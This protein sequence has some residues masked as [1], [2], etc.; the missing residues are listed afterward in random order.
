MAI[1]F[2]N[3]RRIQYTA[4]VGTTIF[5]YPFLIFEDSDLDV[6][7][8]PLGSTPDPSTDLLTLNVDYTVTGILDQGGGNV[9]LI[10]PTTGG[11]TIT[12]DSDV[13][14][15]QQ[16][17][18]AVGGLF[19]PTTVTFVV[20]K[21]TVLI[22]EIESLI[23]DQGLLYDV[24]APLDT[25][26]DK[27][28]NRLPVLGLPSTGKI[29]VWTKNATGAIIA[30]ELDENI[31][32]SALRGELA[33]P[34]LASPGADL[35]GYFDPIVG[36]TTV[37]TTLT[38]LRNAVLT[39]LFTT[40]DVKITLKV[41]IDPGFIL[42][43]DGTI[44]DAG[45][46]ASNRASSDTE[47]LFVL[48]WNNVSDTYAPVS[49]GRGVSAIDDFNAGKTIQ[50]LRALGRGII[51]A[52]AGSGLTLRE[53]G[54]TGGEETHILLL[55]EIP[56]HTHDF[57]SPNGRDE[58]QTGSS[59]STYWLSSTGVVFPPPLNRPTSSV[60]S[61]NAHNNMPPFTAYNFFMKL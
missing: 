41:T 48:L 16:V 35:I 11:E 25:S 19:S 60:G 1:K 37:D 45:S 57:A 52:G 18:F 61:G 27:K 13:S 8:T 51:S 39:Q 23:R 47:D 20:D 58:R 4:G 24:T 28:D 44:G 55:D 32:A 12:I 43:D 38:T 46:G 40:G 42:M 22:Q 34:S 49:G 54:E 26:S 15:T 9:V 3:G 5:A 31:D 50:V 56:S 2:D 33:D 10:V 53:L 36:P 14:R 6:Y 21:L 30:A 17:D 29:P 7:K 59:T